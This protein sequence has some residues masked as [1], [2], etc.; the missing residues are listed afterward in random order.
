M[1]KR[2]LLFRPDAG[3]GTGSGEQG[4]GGNGDDGTGTGGAGSQADDGTGAGTGGGDAGAQTDPEL[5]KAREE[6]ARNRIALRDAN[7]KLKELED[8]G[9]SG[10]ERANTL[11][12]DLKTQLV[13]VTDKGK[14]AI[15][16]LASVDLGVVME[17]RSDAANLLDWSKIED[18]YD[19]AE[20]T[21]ALKDLV[22]ERPYL[23]GKNGEGADGGAGGGQ[24]T[25]ETMNDRIRAAAGR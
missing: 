19:V 13:S 24:R 18:P 5:K 21:K 23:L 6:A 9:K 14:K 10:L 2:Y 8:A 3:G 20:V 22:K 15:A 4:M 12:E 1:F 25:G 7:A 11:T 17:A 16:M